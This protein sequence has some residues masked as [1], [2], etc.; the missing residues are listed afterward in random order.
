VNGKVEEKG[1][2]TK[3]HEDCSEEMKGKPWEDQEAFTSSDTK[4]Y[5]NA[6]KEPKKSDCKNNDKHSKRIAEVFEDQV[7]IN[8]GT[9]DKNEADD[10]YQSKEQI[11]PS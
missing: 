7:K 2:P 11:H 1:N 6:C 4:I 8:D 10:K 5:H 3:N 9:V